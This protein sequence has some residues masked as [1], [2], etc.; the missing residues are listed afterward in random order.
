MEKVREELNKLENPP[1]VLAVTVL[2]SM[3]EDDLKETGVNDSPAQQVKRLALLAK[4]SGMDG[5]V[6][7]P[8]EIELIRE[9]CGEDFKILTPG[10]RPSFASTDDQKR[11]ATPKSALEKGSDYL[12]IGRPITKAEN[13]REAFKKILEEINS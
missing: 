4:E 13:R 11:I 5:V 7:S 12:V 10:I 6:A 2:T 8:L 1:M 9:A 3:G